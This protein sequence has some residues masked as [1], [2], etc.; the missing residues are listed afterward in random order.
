LKEGAIWYFLWG[1]DRL[2]LLPL[3]EL[4]DDS[5]QHIREYIHAGEVIVAMADELVGHIQIVPGLRKGE[6][7]LKSMAVVEHARSLG[8]GGRLL[9]AAVSYS[10]NRSG[11]RL[12]VST[13]IASFAAIRFYL[14]R[15]F[16]P[17]GIV[18]DAFSPAKGY[19]V[20]GRLD[21]VPL[22]DAIVLEMSLP[23]AER[24][25]DSSLS[26]D[27]GRK[28]DKPIGRNGDEQPLE[29]PIQPGQDKHANREQD[30]A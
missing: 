21:G 5:T 1:R 23:G 24:Q 9:E 3:F 4:A 18:R 10:R 14:C 28:L 12:V 8:I 29:L 25:I 30:D 20:D 22:R 19:L 26:S 17:S 11:N 16:R 15:G 2:E 13:A 27:R 6:F 7:E